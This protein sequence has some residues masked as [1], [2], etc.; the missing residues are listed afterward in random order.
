MCWKGDFGGKIWEVFAGGQAFGV[1][2]STAWTAV[3]SG[4]RSLRFR[5]MPMRRVMFEDGQPT[6]APCILILTMPWG[7]T[8]TSSMSPPSFWTAGLMRS[9]TNAT[10]SWRSLLCGVGLFGVG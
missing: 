8:S 6:H 1:F 7:V 9:M 10:R 4:I 3:T 5:S 2:S